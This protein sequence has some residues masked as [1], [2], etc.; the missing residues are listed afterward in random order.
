MGKAVKGIKKG[1]KAIGRGVKSIFKKPKVPTAPDPITEEEARAP[2][3]A[4]V[5][6]PKLAE[7]AIFQRTLARR[8]SGRRKQF[9]AD[10]NALAAPTALKTLLG[11]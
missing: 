3:V 1:F 5:I 4:P 10:D 2:E 11:S 9:R 7:A 6:A 8:R